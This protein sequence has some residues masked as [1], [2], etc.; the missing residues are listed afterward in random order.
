M[1]DQRA[2]VAASQR[3]QVQAEAAKLATDVAALHTE[4][5]ETHTTLVAVRAAHSVTPAALQQRTPE[6][7]RLAQQIRDLTERLAEHDGFRRS[8]EK[9]L[10]HAHQ[11]L[12]HFRNAS[13][14]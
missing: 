14:E 4:L 9:K 8:L 13:K 3:Q 11:A 10:Q 1:V 12:E 7:E 2:T 6:T 5:A